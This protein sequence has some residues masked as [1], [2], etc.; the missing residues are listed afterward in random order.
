MSESKAH[1][2]RISHLFF[3]YK[4]KMII[5]VF[6]M[7][8]AA[9]CTGFHAWLV[10]PALDQVLVNANKFYLYFIPGAI[11]VTGLIKGLATYT[12]VTSLQF[13]SHRI[14][15]KL[16]KDV[17]HNLINLHYGFFVQNRTGSLITRITTDTYYLSGAMA[18]TYTALIKDSLTLLVLMGNMFYQNWKLALISIVIFP[19][20]LIPV[21]VLGKK[22]RIITKNL[23]YQ[24]GNLASNLE[25]IFK[26]IKNVKSFNAE[27]FEISR[28]N[29]EIAAARELNFKQEK[30]TARSRPFTE[31]LG[32]LAAGLAIF[33]GGVFVINKNMTA[34]ELMSFLVSLMLAY[35]PLK[36]LINVNVLLQSGLGAASR[37]FE[38]IDMKSDISDGNK[39]IKDF[40]EIKFKDVFFKYPNSEKNVLDGIN[41]NLRKNKKIAI[42][43]PSG[44][45]KST[46][47]VLMIRLFDLDK[48]EIIIGNENIKDLRF[49]NL[50][51]YFSLVSQDTVLFDGSI[52]E[53]IKYNSKLSNKSIEK[54]AELA[55]VDEVIE[56]LPQGLNT[57]IGENGIK[58]SGGQRQR[59]AIARALA[60][61]KP[62]ILL[63]EPTSNLDFRTEA[64]LFDNL[65]G[66]KNIS[67]V[68]VAHRLSTIKNFDEIL[69]LE[70]GKLLER[71]SHKNLM[72]KKGSY[73]QLYQK[74]LRKNA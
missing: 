5:A 29:K 52:S 73:Y 20:A 36:N 55:C 53:N 18:N 47:L 14:I 64:K 50:R 58:L 7:I 3:E 51:S 8:I 13:M 6:C 30:V 45:G 38:F 71:G 40:D 12:Q 69:Y 33:G 46:L 49:K 28:I 35:A 61:Q 25:E 48:G 9:L 27:E 32:S 63:D 54:F 59:I 72:K 42:V 43:G 37:I 74:Q 26:G 1:F 70:A 62:I 31:T 44:S 23:Q 41:V 4:I 66:I 67:L 68:V 11:L 17:F 21:R 19:L 16:R 39:T 57:Q 60:Q 34:G 22:I 10:K 15:E 24:I 2:F 56:K 65:Y